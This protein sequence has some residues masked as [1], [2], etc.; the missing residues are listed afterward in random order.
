M[1]MNGHHPA[2]LAIGD[3]IAGIAVLGS[4]SGY[5]PNIAAFLGIIYYAIHIG[6]WIASHFDGGN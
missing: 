3:L 5:L 1:T 2:M 6:R 4:L